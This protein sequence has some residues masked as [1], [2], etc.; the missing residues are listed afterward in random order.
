MARPSGIPPDVAKRAAELAALIRYHRERYF[1]DDDPEISD[2]EFDELV[3]EL[4]G[5]VEQYPLLDAGESP[6]SEVGARRRTFVPSVTSC[7]CC[8]ST[9]CSIAASCSPGTPASRR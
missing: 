8:R 3:R 2:G 7:G 5:L 9:T 1:R 6:L 4:Q